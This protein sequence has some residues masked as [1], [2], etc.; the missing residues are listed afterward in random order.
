MK[1]L[2]WL[3][4][5]LLILFCLASCHHNEEPPVEVKLPIADIFIPATVT[6]DRSDTEFFEKCLEWDNKSLVV[7]SIEELPEDPLGSNDYFKK[8][9]FSKSTLLLSY[10]LHRLQYVT[11]KYY[12]LR[13]RIE[14]S[15]N[16]TIFLG[17]GNLRDENSTERR[18]TRFAV[19]VP[20]LPESAN[21]NIGISYTSGYADWEDDK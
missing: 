8:I 19:L 11:C 6:F 5:S 9:N 18:F 7:N 17:I 10:S 16:L 2:M 14:Q 13:N 12:F 15:Y 21:V 3:L 4:P 1:K 20:K